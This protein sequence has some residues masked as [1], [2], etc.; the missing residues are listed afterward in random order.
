MKPSWKEILVIFVFAVLTTVLSAFFYFARCRESTGSVGVQGLQIVAPPPGS[1]FWES[2]G[3]PL[4]YHDR[5]HAFS[6]IGFLLDVLFYIVIFSLV[7]GIIKLI[8]RRFT[9]KS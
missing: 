1:C 9:H 4:P 6:G 3:F 2:Y 7:W 8:S 5:L